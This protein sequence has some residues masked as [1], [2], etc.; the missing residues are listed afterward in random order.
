MCAISRSRGTGLGVHHEGEGAFHAS[1]SVFIFAYT[2]LPLCLYQGRGHGSR[3]W[4]LNKLDVPGGS[5][6]KR[7]YGVRRC[8]GV[9][10]I[11]PLSMLKWAQGDA[12][13]ALAA[14][15]AVGSWVIAVDD[16]AAAAV[17]KVPKYPGIHNFY[18]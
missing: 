9:K 17:I 8:D 13:A 15:K 12:G 7:R 2:T 1:L 11:D 16:D 6:E 18:F 3:A 14:L 10:W 5:L 4:V